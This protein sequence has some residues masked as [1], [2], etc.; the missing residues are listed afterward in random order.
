MITYKRGVIRILDRKG[1]EKRSCE[2]YGAVRA[3]IAGALPLKK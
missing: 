3:A 2:C 1:V